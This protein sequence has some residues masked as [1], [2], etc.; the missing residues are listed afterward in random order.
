MNARMIVAGTAVALLL[1]GCATT[2]PS[3]PHPPTPA[4]KPPVAT[5]DPFAEAL[6]RIGSRTAGQATAIGGRAASGSVY[7]SAGG[8]TVGSIGAAAV[9]NT[10]AE[11]QRWWNGL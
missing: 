11:I 9:S 8:G 6:G 1:A 10:A 5:S 3:Q 2:P 4:S 7:Q